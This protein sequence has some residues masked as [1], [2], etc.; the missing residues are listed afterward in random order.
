[1]FQQDRTK[2]S[3]MQELNGWAEAVVI[4]PLIH[5]ASYGPEQALD[6]TKQ[7]VLK[8]IREKVLESYRNGQAAGPARKLSQKTYAK[9]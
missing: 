9:R 7:A 5:A 6:E 8:A 3:Y 4:D 1:M 2:S